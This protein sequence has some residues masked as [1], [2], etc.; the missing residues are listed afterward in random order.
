MSSSKPHDDSPT[1]ISLREISRYV[2]SGVRSTQEVVTYLR[3]HGVPPTH[4]ARLVT[5]YRAKGLLDDR[6]SARLWA[7]HWARRGYATAAIR[8]KLSA[9]GFDEH[10]I[11]S[12]IHQRYPPSDDEERARA[13][14][15]QRVRRTAVRPARARLARTLAS[16]GFDSD[17]IERILRN[18][19]SQNFSSAE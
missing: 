6:A 12:T 9:K 11:N 13:V 18:F 14:V 17:V 8:V 15:A 7:E 2:R 5:E 4:A 19:A 3:R 1:E 10:V 16:R